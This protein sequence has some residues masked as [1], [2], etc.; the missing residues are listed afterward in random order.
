VPLR[1]ALRLT[2]QLARPPGALPAVLRKA[3][4]L[5]MKCKIDVRV[6]T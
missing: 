1:Q 5:R 4:W 2:Q 6:V 3:Q